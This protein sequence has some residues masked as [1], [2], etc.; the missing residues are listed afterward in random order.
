MINDTV[1]KEEPD[2]EINGVQTKTATLIVKAEKK[3]S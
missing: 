2:L 1:E 3:S